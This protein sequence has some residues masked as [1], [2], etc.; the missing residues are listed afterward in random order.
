MEQTFLQILLS[1]VEL[2]GHLLKAVHHILVFRD[3]DVTL[4]DGIMSFINAIDRVSENFMMKI[5]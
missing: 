4:H 1:L 5:P 2:L 3:F